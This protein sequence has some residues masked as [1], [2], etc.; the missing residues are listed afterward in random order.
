[1]AGAAPS[2]FAALH[3]FVGSGRAGEGEGVSA[4]AAT[5]PPA[6]VASLPPSSPE[7]WA[8]LAASLAAAGAPPAELAGIER[9]L[10]AVLAISAVPVTYGIGAIELLG[11]EAGYEYDAKSD[12]GIHVFLSVNGS[13]CT[14]VTEDADGNE[15]TDCAAC[16]VTCQ[17]NRTVKTFNSLVELQQEPSLTSTAP[18][19][20]FDGMTVEVTFH[21]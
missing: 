3:L 5:A 21:A 1:V 20:T 4:G 2:T 6:L 8:G 7:A 15:V 17:I 11:S 18:G 12:L 14:N 10:G 19:I 16:A 9:A 13:I